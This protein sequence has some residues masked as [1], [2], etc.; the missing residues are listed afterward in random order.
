MDPHAVDR[1]EPHSRR[2]RDRSDLHEPVAI[3]MPG[4]VQRG[5]RADEI[6]QRR[7]TRRTAR[8]AGASPADRGTGARAHFDG[9]PR[10]RLRDDDCAIAHGEVEGVIRSS[11]DDGGSGRHLD[12]SAARFECL[13]LRLH[14]AHL[15]EQV[16]ADVHVVLDG[17]DARARV[18]E[19][20]D[21]GCRE[22]LLRHAVRTPLRHADSV[23]VP[24]ARQHELR[25]RTARIGR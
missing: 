16:D 6:E 23:A 19:G 18:V 7:R 20:G 21:V 5:A 15:V 9:L 1:V 3:A 17:R 24:G 13:G 8:H 12:G 10:G 22:A 25:R 4:G 2:G 11:R 14:R